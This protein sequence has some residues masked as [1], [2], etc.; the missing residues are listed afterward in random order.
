VAEL[1]YAEYVG[2]E[3]ALKGLKGELIVDVE[4]G[5]VI[6]VSKRWPISHISYRTEWRERGILHKSHY[7]KLTELTYD[8]ERHYHVE[9]KSHIFKVP[10]EGE[11]IRTDIMKA[12]EKWET[13]ALDECRQVIA[14]L[15]NSLGETK[16]LIADLRDKIKGGAV[17]VE[18]IQRLK[19][20]DTKL[21]DIKERALDVLETKIAFIELKAEEGY[22]LRKELSDLLSALNT[23]L[24]QYE[25]ILDS[26]RSHIIDQVKKLADKGEKISE[27]S[28]DEEILNLDSAAREAL[29]LLEN[30]GM[31]WPSLIPDLDTMIDTL[32][33]VIK[34]IE[35]I[36]SKWPMR[37]VLILLRNYVRR[38]AEK[39]GRMPLT[40]F[41]KDPRKRPPALVVAAGTKAC[42]TIAYP[43]SVIMQNILEGTGKTA[44]LLLVDSEIGLEDFVN[45]EK[46]EGL[47]ERGQGTRICGYKDCDNTVIARARNSRRGMGI[48][49]RMIPKAFMHDFFD[50]DLRNISVMRGSFGVEDSVIAFI[51]SNGGTG[52]SVQLLG[53]HYLRFKLIEGYRTRY[54]WWIGSR[55]HYLRRGDP[56]QLWDVPLI[57]AFHAFAKTPD[58]DK[59]LVDLVGEIESPPTLPLVEG[60]VLSTL[61]FLDYLAKE[62]FLSALWGDLLCKIDRGD[63]ERD[64][65]DLSRDGK[66][67]LSLTNGLLMDIGTCD[68]IL[69]LLDAGMTGDA[70]E[71]LVEI[72]RELIIK[73]FETIGFRD[74]KS[75]LIYCYVCLPRAP[76]VPR[77]LCEEYLAQLTKA[78]EEYLTEDGRFRLGI[79]IGNIPPCVVVRVFMDPEEVLKQSLRWLAGL[80]GFTPEAFREYINDCIER[81]SQWRDIDPDYRDE[82]VKAWEKLRDEILPEVF[83][84]V[85]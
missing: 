67:P 39:W 51:C 26:L 25:S 45:R 53:G 40:D 63:A 84:E 48:L 16:N 36:T 69:S 11:L 22:K 58:R 83:Q 9:Y 20:I 62:N 52:K 38:Q 14:D 65:D 85:G 77:L 78:L 5:E 70:A 64:L 43:W 50:R 33:G 24:D 6:F 68:R 35:D 12:R 37:K 54:I 10:E 13:R 76:H 18:D 55:E 80:R 82:I 29:S 19:S 75:P 71:K 34:K 32:R 61:P 74:A 42:N 23:Q 3:E 49:I 15:R 59:K 30:I 17:G 47:E 57:I 60:V 28:P 73:A 21:S 66:V 27:S 44:G 1:V 4:G 79:F 46:E 56:Q 31:T 7:L 41:V 72:C 81:F 8:P 2:T